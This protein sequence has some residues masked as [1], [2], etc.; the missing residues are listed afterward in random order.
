[1]GFILACTDFH[2]VVSKKYLLKLAIILFL[3]KI[4]DVTKKINKKR[5][6]STN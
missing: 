2:I 4:Q 3:S 6:I 5:L 1:V